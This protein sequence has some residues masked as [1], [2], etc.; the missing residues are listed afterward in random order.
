[1]DNGIA[2]AVYT[3]GEAA[4]RVLHSFKG[5]K[6]GKYDVILRPYAK[7]SYTVF[8]GSLRPDISKSELENAFKDYQPL[9]S[10]NINHS[11]NLV[12]KTATLTFGSQYLYLDVVM[13]ILNC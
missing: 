12:S 6:I 3:N 9:I 10:C 7:D 2:L 5:N 1:M 13:C 8:V 4:D 11:S